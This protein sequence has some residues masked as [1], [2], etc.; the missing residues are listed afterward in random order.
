M[1]YSQ[2]TGLTVESRFRAPAHTH[3]A[4]VRG[5]VIAAGMTALGYADEFEQLA[6]IAG[7][8]LGPVST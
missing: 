7:E 4:A 8:R 2:R 1:I 5:N 3:M 6:D